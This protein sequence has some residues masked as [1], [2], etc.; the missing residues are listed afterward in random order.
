MPTMKNLI[1]T[2]KML[3]DVRAM[4][5]LRQF[6]EQRGQFSPLGRL[7]W[8][9]TEHGTIQFPAKDGEPDGPDIGYADNHGAA[10]PASLSHDR[11]LLIVLGRWSGLPYVRVNTSTPCPKCRHL[12]NVC[13][14]E[15][16]KLC[17][18]C[19]GRKW[20]PG[21]W[22]PCPG[23]G[24]LKATGQYKPDCVTCLQSQV[25]GQIREERDCAMCNG[26]GKMVCSHC[27]G[28][29][30]YSTGRLNGSTNW[31]GPACKACEGMCVV[32]KWQKQ[33]VA[34]FLNARLVERNDGPDP[35]RR[36]ALTAYLVLGP[37]QSFALREFESRHTRIFDVT[38]DAASDL[39]MLLVPSSPKQ[40]PSKAY[41]IGGIVRERD[42]HAA[43]A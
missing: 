32:G 35:K 3:P 12:C 39:L 29:G 27:K 28:S 37:I 11:N 24:C 17:E 4:I 5:E 2:S 30:K 10:A 20:V 33:D 18:L 43:S 16:K 41:L 21:E 25:R 34:R 26:N 38:L 7:L 15:K 8:L 9:Q 40:K 31:D 36:A 42:A 19:G 13:G 6:A 1:P 23:P 22:L 14:G